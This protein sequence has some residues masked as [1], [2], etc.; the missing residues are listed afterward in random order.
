MLLKHAKAVVLS[1]YWDSILTEWFKK[2][3]E[4]GDKGML[5]LLTEISTIDPSVK[6]YVL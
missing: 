5:R 1:Q 2:A 4:A 6:E 3:K